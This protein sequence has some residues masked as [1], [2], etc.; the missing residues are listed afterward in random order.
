MGLSPDGSIPDTKQSGHVGGRIPILLAIRFYKKTLHHSVID[1]LQFIVQLRYSPDLLESAGG[2]NHFVTAE[3]I[4]IHKE[5]AQLLSA[6]GTVYLP[7]LSAAPTV[8][9][10][11]GCASGHRLKSVITR[12][13]VPNGSGLGENL[14]LILD[15][16]LP[17]RFAPRLNTSRGSEVEG[18]PF[19]HSFPL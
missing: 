15:F 2:T 9:L 17:L 18:S 19:S 13:S 16:R 12:S 14:A 7:T 8:L 5:P 10:S 4:P 6:S 3:F 1:I 11:F